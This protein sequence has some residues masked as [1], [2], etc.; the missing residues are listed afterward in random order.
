MELV[1][2]LR[3]FTD[4]ANGCS[5]LAELMLPDGAHMRGEDWTVFYLGQSP[6]SSVAPM[7]THESDTVDKA[8]LANKRAS[9]FPSN[10]RPR[11]GAP[12][13]GLLY[14]LNCVRM[15]ED[16]TV[17]R[18]AMVK[19]LAI[20]T[21][22]PYI[23]IFKPLLLL[24]LEEYFKN[25]SFDILARLYDSANNISLVGMPKL[26][27][28]ELILLRQTDRKDLLETRFL[29]AKEA[30]SALSAIDDAST[31]EGST[32]D[33]ERKGSVSSSVRPPIGRKGSSASSSYPGGGSD[34][35]PADKRRGLPRDTHFFETEARFRQITVPIRV[36]MTVFDEDVGDYT[37]IEL[38]QTFGQNVTT[39]PGPY[40]PW[41][42]TNGAHTHPIML[43]FNAILCH[44][45]V[46]F[47]GHGLP[48]NHVARMVL[49]A[50]AMVTGSG[51]ILRGVTETAFPYTNLA[52][53]EVL[54]QFDGFV[55]G[56]CNPRFEELPQ[57]WDV[58][59]NLETGKV[60]V[61]KELRGLGGDDS[62]PSTLSR[63][64]TQDVMNSKQLQSLTKDCIDNQFMEEIMSATTQHYG[65][66]HIRTRFTD[67]ISRFV[68][69]AAY[70]EYVIFGST[71]VGW[72][73]QPF[74]EGQ[75]GSGIVFIDDALRQRE[76][77]E[78]HYR[79]DAWRRTKSYR[80]AQKD[81][82]REEQTAAIR[83]FD[84]LHNVKRLRMT[85]TMTSQE[86]GL[87][88]S[89]FVRGIRTYDQVVELLTYLPMH[90][91]GL[92]P[93]ANGL[94]HPISKIRADALELLC[95]IQQYPVGIQALQ[96]L[97]Y[98]HRKTF[99]E[100]LERR[101]AQRALNRRLTEER[102]VQEEARDNA[103]AS[104]P[105]PAPT[106][107]RLEIRTEDNGTVRRG[108]LQAA[109]NKAA[110]AAQAA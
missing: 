69:L 9:M 14:V 21:P 19:A 44:K 8:R 87:I 99:I 84:A 12:G 107:N 70:Q 48:A 90:F 4:N 43:I 76:L 89:T 28:S 109:L 20:A 2:G 5:V 103:A 77:K 86:A 83:G 60:T 49:A 51:Q 105:A 11:R 40:F 82:V 31:H 81:W 110:A 35:L 10:E 55:A 73:Y 74:R 47:L 24:A 106:A 95:I 94:F 65:E 92:I 80:L 98:F 7:L 6:Q 57:T 88:F 32:G 23:G 1:R 102:K 62:I 41:L 85:R 78:N 16:K 39:F 100:L 36:P 50:C 67:Y 42:H 64:E 29:E 53:L 52:S 68:R 54:E 108:E 46:M 104:P 91:G 66:G 58:L 3:V 15:K 26:T 27:R 22:H 37:I 25:P 45:R 13:G 59:C 61:S 93:I 18:G 72:I 30:A 33:H 75:L 56:T 17:R 96:G 97:N 34:L 38:V 71:N 79:I 101:E 63:G